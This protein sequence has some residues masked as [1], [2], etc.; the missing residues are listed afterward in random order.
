VSLLLLLRPRPTGTSRRLPIT[1]VKTPPKQK[2][3]RRTY[4]DAFLIAESS[5]VVVIAAEV[6]YNFDV[7]VEELILAGGI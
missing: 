1:Y 5:S 4:V 6:T 3:R 7:E 2:P